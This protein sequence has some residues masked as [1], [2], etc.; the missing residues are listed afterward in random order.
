[1][2]GGKENLEISERWTEPDKFTVGETMEVVFNI[3]NKGN[4]DYILS[5]YTGDDLPY[6]IYFDGVK[7]Y[8]GGNAIIS[9]LDVLRAGDQLTIKPPRWDIDQGFTWFDDYIEHEIR[10]EFLDMI[11]TFKK[12][13][14]ENYAPNQVECQY[15]RFKN[16]ITVCSIDSDELPDKIR[17]GLSWN[18]NQI[19][20]KW[21]G[22]Y[23][24]GEEI[25]IGCGEHKGIFG[26]IAEDEY[27]A[28]SEWGSVST[29]KVKNR[30]EKNFYF[31]KI[32]MHFKEQF[33]SLILIFYNFLNKNAILFANN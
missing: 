14:I 29:E 22:Y 20:D 16:E 4:K 9:M 3:K 23:T 27:G 33:K 1:M 18:N 32:I 25:N 10:I 7:K 8:P 12:T 11:E 17:Y 26:V 13:A 24:A 31:N 19:V 21:Y 2:T 5:G 6:R 15:N 30:F 28:R